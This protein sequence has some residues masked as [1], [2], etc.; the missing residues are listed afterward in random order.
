MF[1]QFLH[2]QLLALAAGGRGG[3]SRR[4]APAIRRAL[5]WA[6]FLSRDPLY[7]PT[8]DL[9]QSP[10]ASE[11]VAD[12]SLLGT[13]DCA[14]FVGSS[15][16]LDD[17]F[18]AKKTHFRHTSLL[19]V[20]EER[21]SY[22]RLVEFEPLLE[23]RRVNTTTD[24]KHRWMTEVGRFTTRAPS[25][26]DSPF[27]LQLREVA[28]M[29]GRS[30]TNRRLVGALTG[31]PRRLE[32][33]AFLWN[34]V[35]D[36]RI[37]PFR[38]TGEPGRRIELGLAWHWIVSH[39]DEYR[40]TLLVRIPG[41]G[42]MDFG[43]ASTHPEAVV[44]LR[45][46]I[47]AM[48]LLKLDKAFDCL[49]LEQI[50]ALRAEPRMLCL[51]DTLVAELASQ[52]VVRSPGARTTPGILARAQRVLDA[53]ALCHSPSGALAAA[54]DVAMAVS[55]RPAS[56]MPSGRPII[57]GVVVALVEE[58]VTIRDA[59]EAVMG[60]LT[61]LDSPSTGRTTYRIT[62][63]R[64]DGVEMEYV[65]S[66][67]G[68]GQERAA[69]A[70]AHFIAEHRPEVVVNI[71]IAGALSSDVDIGDVVV[72]DTVQSYLSDSKASQ[73][74]Q[75]GFKIVPGGQSVTTDRYLTDRATEI[76]L[77]DRPRITEARETLAAYAA[78]RIDDRALLDRMKFRVVAGPLACGPI[79]GA[80]AAFKTA[81][82]AVN[83]NLV[84]LDMESSGAG[85]ATELG[86]MLDRIRYLVLRGISDFADA[87]KGD[88]EASTKGSL[89]SVATVAPLHLMLAVLDSVPSEFLQ[90]P[91]RMAQSE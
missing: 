23:G 22:E 43:V 5:R 21:A 20:W 19:G 89:R 7:I 42:E 84:A 9:V 56:Y 8:V 31:L 11:V 39:L 69:A 33:H 60:Q 64:P 14:H 78:S 27:L 47:E 61:P 54:A 45:A 62:R 2:D 10:L 24:L 77:R 71:G 80:A 86:G 28:I 63:R 66:L 32:D 18:R 85:I 13:R 35:Q 52:F 46:H 91:A 26:A 36:L 65:F 83:R 57:I 16:V 81:L 25:P 12:L 70:T 75:R 73:A 37:F 17:L 82:L 88:L 41:L 50:L 44:D 30:A 15:V 74:G 55:D 4:Q 1:V 38:T 53:V 68:K 49:S 34:V 48:R 29:L 51:R 3:A 90:Q 67:I 6:S 87:A 79:V 40:T 59:V 58:L 72:A 76:E